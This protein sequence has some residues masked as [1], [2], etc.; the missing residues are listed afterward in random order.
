MIVS[1]KDWHGN[2][3]SRRDLLERG[4]KMLEDD[5]LP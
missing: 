3:L 5:L 1:L 2:A 4:E